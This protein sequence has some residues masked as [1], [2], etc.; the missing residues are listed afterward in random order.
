MSAAQPDERRVSRLMVLLLVLSIAAGIGLLVLY[1][2]GGQV[3]LEGALI[4]HRPG[5]RWGS[6]S[7]SGANTCT[8]T[9]W[10]PKGAAARVPRPGAGGSP[11][12]LV[13]ETRTGITRR[14]MAHP[15]AGRRGRGVRT[16][17]DLPDP[18]AWARVRAMR[19]SRRPGGGANE[20]STTT[21]APVRV[22]TLS[23]W[24]AWSPCSRRGLVGNANAQGHPGARGTRIS[25]SCRRAAAAGRPGGERVLLED[26]HARRVSPLG[27]T[28]R[29]DEPD[30]MPVS[31]VGV[32]RAERRRGGVRRR[33]RPLPQLPMEVDGEGYLRG[34]RG[35]LRA[36]GAG[37]L[38]PG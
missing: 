22:D 8:P 9:R 16:R 28:S 32:R 4:G 33:P 23:G 1:A 38:E 34:Q 18:V 7:S 21:G 36:G 12:D 31:L 27:C 6:R 5:Q 35:R 19:C 24:T 14:K 11:E 13:E 3:Q 26:L 15:V 25:S 30:A 20:W 37:V 29:E 2:I 10:S 17:A